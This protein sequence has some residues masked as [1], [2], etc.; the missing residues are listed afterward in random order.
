MYS[1][2]AWFRWL[3]VKFLSKQAW[4][5]HRKREMEDKGKVS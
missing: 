1:P 2:M 3:G 4:D 5:K